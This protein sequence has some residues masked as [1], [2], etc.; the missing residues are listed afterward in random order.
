MYVCV[1]IKYSWVAI[2]TNMLSLYKKHAKE[3]EL[4][5]WPIHVV[6]MCIYVYVRV[7]EESK[8]KLKDN[9]SAICWKVPRSYFHSLKQFEYCGSSL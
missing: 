3:S 1:C 9:V 2:L 6:G 8:H 4:F 7:S 5:G